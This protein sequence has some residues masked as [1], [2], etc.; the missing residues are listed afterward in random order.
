M[1]GCEGAKCKQSPVSRAGNTKLVGGTTMRRLHDVQPV[2]IESGRGDK[3][4]SVKI[5][6]YRIKNL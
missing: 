3:Y 5:I 2:R 6:I 1:R 4:F